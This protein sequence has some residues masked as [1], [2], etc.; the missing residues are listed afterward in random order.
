M[1]AYGWIFFYD[2]RRHIETASVLDAIGGNG[3]L[4]I[5]AANGEAVALGTARRPEE[6]ILRFEQE[7]GL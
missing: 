2:S 1:N 5:L 7:R 3:S 6:E 4:V